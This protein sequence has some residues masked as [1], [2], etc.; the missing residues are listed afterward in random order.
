MIN[1]A[2]EQGYHINDG[3]DGEGYYGGEGGEGEDGGKSD[4]EGSTKFERKVLFSN[5]DTFSAIS[6]VQLDKIKKRLGSRDVMT[7]YYQQL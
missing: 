1:R 5:W 6:K 4:D 3:D 2:E 7:D